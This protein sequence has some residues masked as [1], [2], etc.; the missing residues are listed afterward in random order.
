METQMSKTEKIV[1]LAILIAMTI[2]W[3]LMFFKQVDPKPIPVNNTTELELKI[4]NQKLQFLIDSLSLVDSLHLVQLKEKQVIIKY[5]KDEIYK[6]INFIP[7]ADS[8]YKDSLWSVHLADSV[9]RGSV[10]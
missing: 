10:N 9:G 4:E 7:N 2:A 8:K 5:K 1:I 6:V 3:G